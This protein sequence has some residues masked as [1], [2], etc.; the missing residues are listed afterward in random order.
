MSDN[1][2]SDAGLTDFVYDNVQVRRNGH[3]KSM[4]IMYLS[5]NR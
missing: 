1:L 4:Y 3:G 2:L 5:V